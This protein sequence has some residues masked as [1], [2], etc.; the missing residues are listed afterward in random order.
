[1]RGFCW[2]KSSQLQLVSSLDNIYLYNILYNFL[3][4]SQLNKIT[5]D[6]PFRKVHWRHKEN[7]LMPFKWSNVI[8]KFLNALMPELAT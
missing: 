7:T 8:I 4:S 2:E 3:Q 1:M 5:W 6:Y